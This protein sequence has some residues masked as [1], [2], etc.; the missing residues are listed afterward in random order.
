MSLFKQQYKTAVFTLTITLVA[1]SCSPTIE[2]TATNYHITKTPPGLVKIADNFYYDQTEIC[3]VHWR[4]FMYWTKLIFGVNS[5]E[6]NATIPDTLV[7]A[8]NF[9]C[10]KS[11]EANYLRSP[12]FDFY[13]VVGITQK[14]AKD[15]SKWRADRVF[16]KLLIDLHKIDYDSV[17]NSNTYFTIDKYFAGTYKDYKPG[18]K[19]NYFP[20]YRLPTIKERIQIIQ[21]ADPIDRNYLDTCTSKYCLDY[22]DMFPLFRSGFNPCVMDS[23]KTIPTLDARQPYSAI[24]GHPIYHFRGNVGEWASENG[25]T[26]GGSWY[27]SRQIILQS[28]TFH[29]ERQNSWT[30]FRNVFSWK[31]WEK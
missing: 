12:E 31:L 30:G 17:Q 29:V 9:P 28:D 21:Y 20:D 25:V 24:I 15:F 11:Y 6:Y 22:K 27:D 3:N 1:L 13:P 10:L 26:F 2:I 4:E 16:E 19:I 23:I 8:Q 5:T 14:Q 7:W 18:K